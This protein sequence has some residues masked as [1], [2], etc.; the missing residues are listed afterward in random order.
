MGRVRGDS[1]V[2]PGIVAGNERSKCHLHNPC[3]KERVEGRSQRL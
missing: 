3:S 1:N 2:C